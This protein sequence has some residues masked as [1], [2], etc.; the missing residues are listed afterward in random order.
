MT[1][2]IAHSAQRWQQQTEQLQRTAVRQRARIAAALRL[3]VPAAHSRR[4]C[5]PLCTDCGQPY[6]CPTVQALRGDER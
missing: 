5:A 3:H 6:P 2:T 1:A 4:R